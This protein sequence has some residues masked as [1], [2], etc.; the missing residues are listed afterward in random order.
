MSKTHPYGELPVANEFDE[1]RAVGA[2][3]SIAQMNLGLDW[4]H[5]FRL[6]QRR[7]GEVAPV[8]Q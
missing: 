7:I 3:E 2:V 6:E 4:T 8:W 5:R 1:H